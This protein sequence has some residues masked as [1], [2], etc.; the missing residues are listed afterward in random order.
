MSIDSITTGSGTGA[1]GSTQVSRA[2]AA[3]EARNAERVQ[4][5]QAEQKAERQENEQAAKP[6][7]VTNA[8]GQQTGTLINV[9]A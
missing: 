4:A 3:Q 6:K 8:L 2:D 9:T 7:P 5:R 1:Y